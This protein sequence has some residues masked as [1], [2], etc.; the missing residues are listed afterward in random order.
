MLAYPAIYNVCSGQP[1]SLTFK[2]GSQAPEK[3]N[4]V[5]PSACKIR[6]WQRCQLNKEDLDN[7]EMLGS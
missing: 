4:A 7:G 1:H 3:A 6:Q 2:S 5:V